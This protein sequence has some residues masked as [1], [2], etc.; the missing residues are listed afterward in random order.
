MP[1]LCA[2]STI[3]EDFH[4]KDVAFRLSPITFQPPL[5]TSPSPSGA[6]YC[7]LWGFGL[8][9]HGG[10]YIAAISVVKPRAKLYQR[11]ISLQGHHP[12][13]IIG[14]GWYGMVG[15][16]FFFQM[17]KYV[18]FLMEGMHLLKTKHSREVVADQWLDQVVG[19]V[20][21][22][23]TWETSRLCPGLRLWALLGLRMPRRVVFHRAGVALSAP[24]A[25]A[26][27]FR[28]QLGSYDTRDG[29]DTSTL[30]RFFGA[31]PFKFNQRFFFGGWQ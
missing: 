10:E 8:S 30:G 20:R 26:T 16:I 28:T 31:F 7:R 12:R 13:E 3:R 27:C 9:H 4:V 6:Y 18:G 22:W 23:K 14:D 24:A 19:C 21:W 25:T 5:P 2:F 29:N 17:D 1:F 11:G 15:C